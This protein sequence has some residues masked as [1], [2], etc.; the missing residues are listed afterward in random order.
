AGGSLWGSSA[1]LF[2]PNTPELQFFLAFVIAGVSSGAV[3][4]LSVAAQAATASVIPCVMPLA[5][6]FIFAGDAL[7]S[8]MG[9]MTC[10]YIGVVTLVARRG[11]I[12]LTRMVTSRLEAQR[13]RAALDTSEAQRRTIDE[14]LRVAAEAGQ[15][16]VWEWDVQ[17]N[18]LTWDERM[19]QIYRI[20]P[21][22][23]SDYHD[24]WRLRVHPADLLRVETELAGSVAGCSRFQSEFRVLWPSGEE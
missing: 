23:G 24:L 20:E 15:I 16:G 18:T 17:A 13:S 7:H 5:L 6:R 11:H 22:P 9:V 14:R 21:V 3:T 19:H 12:Q 8:V 10:F 2:F 4:S 1:L